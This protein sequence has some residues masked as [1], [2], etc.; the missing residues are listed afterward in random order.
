MTLKLF[1]LRD[2]STGRPVKDLF[3]ANKAEARAHRDRL[4][5]DAPRDP[6]HPDAMAPNSFV[7]TLGPDHRNFRA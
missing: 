5:V 7:I 3:F 2:P 4:N 1:T 6:T